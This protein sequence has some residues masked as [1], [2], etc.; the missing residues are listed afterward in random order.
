MSCNKIKSILIRKKEVSF[1]MLLVYVLGAELV[2]FTVCF[3]FHEMGFLDCR[4]VNIEEQATPEKNSMP[5]QQTSGNESNQT[6]NNDIPSSI[7]TPEFSTSDEPA[8]R[9]RETFQPSIGDYFAGDTSKLESEYFDWLSAA[10]DGNEWAQ[11]RMGDFWFAGTAGYSN[12]CEALK[13]W[14]ASSEQGNIVAKYRLIKYYFLTS[15][16]EWCRP[17]PL[18]HGLFF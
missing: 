8:Y 13:W 2:G 15:L 6:L 3:F 7:P 12:H 5:E 4:T 17:H 10:T 16:E 18:L 1:L 11:C 9:G 14:L